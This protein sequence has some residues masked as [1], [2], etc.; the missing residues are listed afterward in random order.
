MAD[1][2]EELAEG[3]IHVRDKLQFELKSE[4][5]CLPA[6]E[7]NTYTL[8]FFIF[9]PASLQI[10]RDTYTKTQF[11]YDQTNFIRLKTPGFTLQEL[12]DVSQARSPLYRI[13]AMY[14]GGAPIDEGRVIEDLKLYANIARSA[15]RNRVRLLLDDLHRVSDEAALA[16]TAQEIS[17]L[18]QDLRSLRGAYINWQS[19]LIPRWQQGRMKEYSQY[20]D[21]FVSN[22]AERYAVGLLQE[23]SG[24]GNGEICQARNALTELV[25]AET[26]HRA[27]RKERSPFAN[28][29]DLHM[30]Y[31]VYRGGLLK[32]FV[33]EA[34]F[35]SLKRN[36]P[37]RTFQQVAAALAAGVAMLFYLYFLSFHSVNPVLDSTAFLVVSVLLYVLKDRLKE[38]L[39]NVSA[40][41]AAG[42]FPDYRTEIRTPNGEIILGYLKEYFYGVGS[43]QIPKEI[44]EMRN[45]H[46]HT[47]LEKARRLESVFYFRKEVVLLPQ[48]AEPGQQAYELNDIFR[49]N[50]S[51]FLVKASDPYKEQ[52]MYD[53]KTQLV[54]VVKGPKVYHINIIIRKKFFNPK[55][56]PQV[57]YKKYRVILDKDGIK[58]IEKVG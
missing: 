20:I 19:D 49:F 17:R 39:K 14:E 54:K 44:E 48:L 32:K 11:Y 10:N 47:E 34:L 37:M 21:E 53:P 8:E 52:L 51:R 41:A 35:L 46:Y 13:R 57:E 33:S 28:D 36:E 7:T 18:C 6:L 3:D 2:H 45:T 42:W 50:I 9:V 29:P 1:F 58:R 15:I 55:H 24:K 43:E 56:E 23:L 27:Q 16:A 25:T 4:Y 22:I 30:E 40:R 5:A 12:S 31:A 26:D 38:G